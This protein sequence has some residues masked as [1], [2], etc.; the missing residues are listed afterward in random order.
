MTDIATVI[1]LDQASGATSIDWVMN[2]PDLA[3]E[4]G[5]QGAL[6]RSIFT[7]R[8]AND[9]DEMPDAI[10]GD[11]APDRRGWWGDTPPD[12]SAAVL[13]GSRLWLMKRAAPS[14]TNARRAELYIREALQWLID[15]GV[16]GR[17]DVA[18]SWL[19]P[20]TLQII[21]TVYRQGAR[22]QSLPQTFTFVWSPTIALNDLP[23]SIAPPQSDL[24]TVDGGIAIACLN[25]LTM[26]T[27]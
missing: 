18:T 26:E 4:D 10:V 11:P 15:G 25:G 5:L 7:D 27:I 12:G 6:L 20:D 2:G 13:N 1:V 24:T 9:D 22:G 21:V 16:A 17:I 14:P 19:A 3:S 8:L 23:P